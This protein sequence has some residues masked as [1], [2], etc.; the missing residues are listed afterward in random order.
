MTWVRP[1]LVA[2]LGFTVKKTA[3]GFCSSKT[4]EIASTSPR[5]NG[6]FPFRFLLREL[7]EIPTNSASFPW[8]M[9]CCAR[10]ARSKLEFKLLH[11]LLLRIWDNFSIARFSLFVNPFVQRF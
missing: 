2:Y 7:G 9:P 6:R 4:R 10:A 1:P 3:A 11:L 8:V 5:V